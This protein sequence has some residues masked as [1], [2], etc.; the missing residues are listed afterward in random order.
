MNKLETWRRLSQLFVHAGTTLHAQRYVIAASFAA[1]FLEACFKLLEPWPLQYL[2]DEILLSSRKDN[3]EI[4]L[5]AAGIACLVLV[6]AIGFRAL[7][8][9]AWTVGFALTG[10]RVLLAV[11]AK[12]FRHLQA[13]SL[14]F[15]SSARMGDLLT[16]LIDDIG[17]VRDVVVTAAMPLAGSLIL[18]TT[19]I[20]VMA[21]L[22]WRLTLIALIGAPV[23]LFMFTRKSTRIRE[24]SKQQRRQVSKVAATAAET[25]SNIKMVQALGLSQATA[26]EFQSANDSDLSSGIKVK[27]LSANME[28]SVDVVIGIVTACTLF[29]G[30]LEVFKARLSVGEFLVFLAYLRATAKPIRNWA[31]FTARVSK[32]AAGAE[33]ILQLLETEPEVTEIANPTSLQNVKGQIEFQNVHFDYQ[34]HCVLDAA[35]FTIRPRETVAIIGSSGSGKSTVV[36]LAVR[37]YDPTQGTVLIDDYDVKDLRLDSIREHVAVALQDALLFHGTLRDNLTQGKTI[38]DASLRNVVEQT[39]LSAVI[40]D[41]D[42]GLESMISEDGANFSNGEKQR[43]S[44]ARAILSDASVLIIDEPLTGLDPQTARAIDTVLREHAQS[45]TFIFVTHDLEQASHADR[46]LFVHERTISDLGRRSAS[47]LRAICTTDMIEQSHA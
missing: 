39:Q 37:L 33:R 35:S 44:L 41:L 40:D 9:Y 34:G 25:L 12:V 3:A 27:R 8:A 2:V 45:R 16:R 21:W 36:S 14:R 32:G 28:R 19:M 10:N 26:S 4:D 42:R 1:L 24:A 11:R 6:L 47:Q 29:A 17:M 13:L 5:Y 46:V 23:L 43:I 7:A 20:A 31:K 18:L 22:N 38:D 30:V 15:H